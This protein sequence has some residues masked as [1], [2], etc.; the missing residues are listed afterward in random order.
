M[1]G[2]CPCFQAAVNVFT[3]STSTLQF[4][5]VSLL[6]LE[7]KTRK[8]KKVWHKLQGA[9]QEIQDLKEEF[10]KEREDM[11]DTIRE[12]NK[13]LKLK[14]LLLEAFVPLQDI[15]RVSVVQWRRFSFVLSCASFLPCIL[16]PPLNP[17]F[18]FLCS[19]SRGPAGTKLPMSG[20]LC[21]LNWPEIE[22]ASAVLLPS[23]LVP[24]RHCL[25]LPRWPMCVP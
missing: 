18:S 19:L 23:S 5:L 20:T 4:Y 2:V 8:L 3:H 17:L 15:E 11:L 22:C 14:Q 25:V 12:L 6:Q 1:R 10:Q 16:T 7:G 21:G 13:Q 9:Q 24:T